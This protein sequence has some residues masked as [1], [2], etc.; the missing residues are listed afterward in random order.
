MPARDRVSANDVLTTP[1]AFPNDDSQARLAA[2][3]GLENHIE[4]LT[5]DL[6]LIFDPQLV[7]DWSQS[8][9]GMRLPAIDL[10]LDSVPLIVFEGDVGTGKSAL[11]EAIGQRVAEDG[12][13][14]VHLVKMSTQV[15]GTGY[16]GEMG[17]LLAESFKQIERISAQRGEPVIFVIDEADSLLTT[18]TSSQHHHEDKSGVNT[19]L[20]HLDDFRRNHA[21][22]GTIAI[23]NRVS[24]LD[25][26]FKRRATSVFTFTRPDADQR[27]RLLKR[28]FGEALSS[29]DIGRLAK[30]SGP[31]ATDESACLPFTYSD[32]TLRFAVPVIRD[33]AWR[34]RKL[35]I[36]HL[37]EIIAAMVPTPSIQSTDQAV[38]RV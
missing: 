18:R 16:V 37:L 10:L 13:Y 31:R 17:T 35:H 26:A 38:Q 28:I 12:G 1:V 2:L 24:V 32:L 33:A 3:V 8:Q 7:E 11:A 29:H 15:R 27:T 9:Y 19:I 20:Q 36:D 4:A 21:Q 5:R 23:T 34:N 30:A 6:R 14:G 22:V 25:P